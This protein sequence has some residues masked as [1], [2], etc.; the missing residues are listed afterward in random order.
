[1]KEA[2]VAAHHYHRTPLSNEKE[3]TSHGQSRAE[4]PEGNYKE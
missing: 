4:T 2:A 1:M 3:W